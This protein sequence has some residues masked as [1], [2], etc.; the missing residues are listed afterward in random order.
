[1]GWSDANGI[2]MLKYINLQVHHDQLAL[3]T[4]TDRGTQIKCDLLHD[5]SLFAI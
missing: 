5:R 4:L 2:L 3:L 1:M